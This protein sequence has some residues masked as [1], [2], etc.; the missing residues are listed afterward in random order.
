[1]DGSAF[2][3]NGEPLDETGFTPGFIS[4]MREMGR[5]LDL[6][7]TGSEARMTIDG[8]GGVSEP[9]KLGRAGCSVLAG[10]A[11]ESG[12]GCH[13]RAQPDHPEIKPGHLFLAD[14]RL[15]RRCFDQIF[16]GDIWKALDD[17]AAKAFDHMR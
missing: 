3:E 4:S 17:C 16:T 12:S 14:R 2:P 13:M 1:M 9:G 11:W 8:G 7:W 5:T 15:F 6:R 10:W